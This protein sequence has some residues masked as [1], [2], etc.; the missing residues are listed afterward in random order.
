M[1]PVNRMPRDARENVGEP[2]PRI[3]AVHLRRHDETV[4][5]RHALATAIGTAEQP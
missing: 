4:H 2:S 3:H 1:K 5:G